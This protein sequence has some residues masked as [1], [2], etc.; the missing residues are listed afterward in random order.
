MGFAGEQMKGEK[1]RVN[2]LEGTQLIDTTISLTSITNELH[3]LKRN[4][5]PKRR[6]WEVSAALRS[7]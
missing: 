1:H 5:N 7:V 4:K 2:D 3:K 6:E